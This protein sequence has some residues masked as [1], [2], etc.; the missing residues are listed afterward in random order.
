MLYIVR[1]YDAGS[2]FDYEYAC[3]EQADEHMRSEHCHA[4]MYVFLN[5]REEYMYSVN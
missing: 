3:Q 1:V 2:I 5:G 4:E